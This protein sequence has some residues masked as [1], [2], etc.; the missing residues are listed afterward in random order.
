M[1]GIAVGMLWSSQ[2]GRAAAK[3]AAFVLKHATSLVPRLGTDTTG[4]VAL[5][6]AHPTACCR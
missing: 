3:V 6:F 1:D 2:T 5:S 4:W